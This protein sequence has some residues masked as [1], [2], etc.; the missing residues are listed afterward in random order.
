VS[1]IAAD[2]DMRVRNLERRVLEVEGYQVL[3][4]SSGHEA[5]EMLAQPIAR[6]VLLDVMMPDLNG[7]E[8]CRKIREFSQVPIIM[9]TSS[10][11]PDKAAGLDA[12]ADDFI[13][14][15]FSPI[16]LVARV[17]AVL[18]RAVEWENPAEPEVHFEG[19]KID[20]YHHQVKLNDA[21]VRLTATEFRLLGCLSRNAGRVLTPDQLLVNVWG[22]EY[23]GESHLLQVNIAR[24]RKKIGDDP[25]QP[26]FITTMPGIG[27]MMPK[28]A[29]NPVSVPA[30][31]GSAG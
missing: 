1:I 27:Y 13:T 10:P 2:S 8:A 3:V 22:E 9:L 12:G 11:D 30:G 15:P 25:R 21:T 23:C 19:L 24:L 17:R 20:L 7:N 28:P 31:K 29:A 4:A 14:K 6:L 16:E 5:L 26:R 18:R